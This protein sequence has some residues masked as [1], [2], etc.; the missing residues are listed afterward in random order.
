[1]TRWKTSSLTTDLNILLICHSQRSRQVKATVTA[2]W[3]MPRGRK[4]THQN[5]YIWG[6]W[7]MSC[8]IPSLISASVVALRNDHRSERRWQ[9]PPVNK[10]C[11]SFDV[12]AGGR[13]E[14]KWGV[15]TRVSRWWWWESRR[16]DGENGCALN[17][18]ETVF[19]ID[20]KEDLFLERCWGLICHRCYRAQSQQEK[21]ETRREY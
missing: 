6:Q 3:G 14:P 4:K 5:K 20:P 8:C 13:K 1:M 16:V 12:W 7:L 10:T 19:D 9:K 11:V 2:A 21:H 17:I 15:K 18:R